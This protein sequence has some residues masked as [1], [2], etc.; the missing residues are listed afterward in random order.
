MVSAVGPRTRATPRT[1]Q[2][3]PAAEPSRNLVVL[4]AEMSSYPLRCCSLSPSTSMRSPPFLALHN[5]RRQRLRPAGT[6]R[7][8][9][10]QQFRMTNDDRTHRRQAS[11]FVGRSIST[12]R[13]A[14]YR[15]SAALRLVRR[16][17]APPSRSARTRDTGPSLVPVPGWVPIDGG[18]SRCTIFP[19]LAFILWAIIVDRPS[20][21][22]H[23][24][25]LDSSLRRHPS[26]VGTA[27]SLSTPPATKCD[28]APST[29]EGDSFSPTKDK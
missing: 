20:P 25:Q 24:T 4:P 6:A 2:P 18:V 28:C 10:A 26:E 27:R 17:T 22:R 29:T 23:A 16:R 19:L 9:S 3:A 12:T 1:R 8:R 13:C 15:P 14:E 11:A 7:C 5:G 21:V